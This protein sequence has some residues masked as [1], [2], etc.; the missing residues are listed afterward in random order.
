MPKREVL[1][2]LGRAFAGAVLF[3]LPLFMTMEIWFLSTAVPRWRL[4]LMAVL[5]VV[6]AVG[7]ARYV[8]FVDGLRTGW[9]DAAVDAGVAVLAGVVAAA[10]VLGALAV[11]HPWQSWQLWVSV[12]LLE[13]L[14]AT[15]G[16][17]FA[18]SQLGAADQPG[19]RESSYRR[20]VFLMSAGAVV[21][22]ANIAPTEEVVLIA[23]RMTVVH[24]I[25]LVALQ[26]TLMHAFVYGV[27]FKG[28][29]ASHTGFAAVFVR[30]TVVGYV[31]A[32]TVSAYLLWT[33]GRYD[34]TGFT[35]AVME[36]IVLGLPAS[37]GAAA[38]R[39]VV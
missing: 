8:G 30:Y 34:G 12:V 28:G 24:A 11:V 19:R 27:G 5:A 10:V 36:M 2:G 16:A 38:A 25:V 23:A 26:L 4:G 33:L 35:A 6:L 32:L 15:V 37:I 20:E 3:A 31:I 22:A 39:L 14:P 13:A 17:S 1:R 29:S 21:L 9:K 7:L 18:R